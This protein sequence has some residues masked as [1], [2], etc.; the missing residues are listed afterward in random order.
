M[1]IDL[2]SF[3]DILKMM[4]C[5]TLE[6]HKQIDTTGGVQYAL[7]KATSSR[8]CLFG[9]IYSKNQ[10]F[11]N[12]FEKLPLANQDAVQRDLVKN[13]GMSISS[14][15]IKIGNS[16]NSNVRNTWEGKC[17]GS[18]LKQAHPLQSDTYV[19]LPCNYTA[20][21]FYSPQGS[22]LM[23]ADL[24]FFYPKTPMLART[25]IFSRSNIEQL[26]RNPDLIAKFELQSREDLQELYNQVDE[27]NK[28]DLQEEMEKECCILNEITI[29]D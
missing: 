23:Q 4:K 16:F 17:D 1:P 18:T 13:S 26:E 25:V 9:F 10:S 12:K 14:R 22:S 3:I 6:F 2:K 15:A 21:T 24:P 8:N 27:E 5:T 11:G 28:I 20:F 19:D 29:E 7:D